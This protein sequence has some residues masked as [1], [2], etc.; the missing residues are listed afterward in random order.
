[1]DPKKAE[2][3]GLNAICLFS[4]S[5][6]SSECLCFSLS[7]CCIPILA[8]DSGGARAPELALLGSPL[9]PCIGWGRMM[10]P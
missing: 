7:V 9:Q 2:S 5:S 4:L 8:S 3:R 6:L 10:G 1:M